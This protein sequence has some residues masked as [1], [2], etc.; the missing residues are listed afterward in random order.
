[1]SKLRLRCDDTCNA[2]FSHDWD[3]FHMPFKHQEGGTPL[4][5]KELDDDE[6]YDGMVCIC[7][8]VEE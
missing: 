6:E 3:F 5:V 2:C 4:C 7:K 8:A 1:M